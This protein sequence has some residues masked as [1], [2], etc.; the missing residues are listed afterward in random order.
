MAPL[1]R[2]GAALAL[3]LALTL[4]QAL[5][6][7]AAQD[8]PGGKRG[9]GGAGGCPGVRSPDAL[10]RREPGRGALSPAV[11]ALS[12]VPLPAPEGMGSGSW[13]QALLAEHPKLMVLPL[14]WTPLL[15][16]GW[17][18]KRAGT[19]WAALQACA[20]WVRGGH[21]SGSCGHSGWG[22]SVGAGKAGPVLGGSS[23]GCDPA[24]RGALARP[25]G[26]W[27][28]GCWKRG[29]TCRFSSCHHNVIVCLVML[30]AWPGLRWELGTS[31]G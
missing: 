24:Q 1:L 7:A 28:V 21:W 9:P 27:K 16:D 8:V 19:P 5:L 2:L 23:A 18:V 3:A 30:T 12:G 15:R 13:Q 26:A 4:T 14:L 6:L 25:S 31:P 17:W 10:P 20:G 11:P 29:F 22:W